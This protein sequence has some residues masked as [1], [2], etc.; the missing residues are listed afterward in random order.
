MNLL[1]TR[2]FFLRKEKTN[3][4]RNVCFATS[5][6]YEKPLLDYIFSGDTKLQLE[7][8]EAKVIQ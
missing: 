4:R 8:K 2:F 3:E 7:S 5:L 1:S 6:V